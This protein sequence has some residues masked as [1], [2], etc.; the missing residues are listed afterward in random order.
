MRFKVEIDVS[1]PRSSFF[2]PLKDGT[3]SWVYFKYERFLIF[4]KKYDLIGHDEDQSTER[5]FHVASPTR[6]HIH[7]FGLWMRVG[8]SI[9]HCFTILEEEDAIAQ[10]ILTFPNPDKVN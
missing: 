5:R 7:L 2:L 1:K 4:C 6:Q 10:G 8:V 9:T 3:Q